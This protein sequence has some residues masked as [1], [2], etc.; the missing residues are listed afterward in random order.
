MTEPMTV[1]PGDRVVLTGQ[2]LDVR[3]EFAL[4]LIDGAQ[5]PSAAI[6]VTYESMALGPMAEPPPTLGA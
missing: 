5:P 4:V 3:G 1:G 2:I 6:A